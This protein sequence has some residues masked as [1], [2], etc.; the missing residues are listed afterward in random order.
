MTKDQK[1]KAHAKRFVSMLRLMN[2]TQVE[3][4]ILIDRTS[5]TINNYAM[6]HTEI[7]STV[8]NT[9]ESLSK[10]SREKLRAKIDRLLNKKKRRE[11]QNEQNN[12]KP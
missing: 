8:F 9:L 12:P 1:N 2:I 10:L 11:K 6:G 4:G 5:Q 3:C 7:H